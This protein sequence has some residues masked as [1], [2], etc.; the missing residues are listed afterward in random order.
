MRNMSV[1]AVLASV[2]AFGPL[3]ISPAL[4]ASGTGDATV[5]ILSA[6]A[7]S[8]ATDLN[9]GKVVAAATGSTVAVGEDGARIC[10]ASLTCYGTTSAGMFNIAGS[11]GETVSVSIDNGTVTLSDGASHI[12]SA[13]V[14]TTTSSV[15]LTGGAG[16]FKVSGQLTVG[17]NQVGGTYAGQYNVSVNYL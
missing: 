5:K 12:M 2:L 4:A 14:S 7:V 8:K 10:G 13:A 3:A 6:L 9:F 11:D 16:S 1:K 15:V 17:A